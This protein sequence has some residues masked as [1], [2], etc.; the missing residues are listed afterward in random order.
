MKKL[1]QERLKELLHYDSETGIFTW[2]ANRGNSIKIGNIA[3]SKNNQGYILITIDQKQY[4]AHRLAWLYVYGYLPENG[5]DHIDNSKTNRHHNWISNLR[6]VSNKCNIR[7]TGNSIN[8][9]SGI[10]G[11][12]WCKRDKMWYARIKIDGKLKHV[13]CSKELHE[14]V[15]FRL[16]AEQCLNW[17]GCD[18][19]SPAFQYV[20]KHINQ[21][22]K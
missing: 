17:E 12:G 5:I 14:A 7:N 21:K 10:K 9:T 20:K 22:A 13:G 2:I 1:T 11:I 8:N 15:C 4:K 3:G 18:S 16:A 19:N 6:E